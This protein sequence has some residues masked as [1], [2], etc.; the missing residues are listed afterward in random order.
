MAEYLKTQILIVH[1]LQSIEEWKKTIVSINDTDE[2]CEETM[3]CS[4]SSDYI[5]GCFEIDASIVIIS[6]KKR[7][8]S[9]FESKNLVLTD[10]VVYRPSRSLNLI[11]HLFY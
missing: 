6:L 9:S 1:N 5:G 11:Q 4:T 8:D 7:R 2:Y 3:T 10:K